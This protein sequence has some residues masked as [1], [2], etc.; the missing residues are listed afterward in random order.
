[1]L[2]EYLYRV[3]THE[4]HMKVAPAAR[5]RKISDSEE[6]APTEKTK[7]GKKLT[8]R[9][10]WIDTETEE[11]RWQVMPTLAR[12]SPKATA[13]ILRLLEEH[14]YR[15]PTSKEHMKVAPAARKRKISDS[16]EKAP[17]EQT[18]SEK[19]LTMGRLASRAM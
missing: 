9:N 1:L 13:A 7:C 12:E 6:K 11:A 18:K 2:D 10:A 19:K 3:S 5:K 17:T 15:V 4:E 16:E 14:L 8:M